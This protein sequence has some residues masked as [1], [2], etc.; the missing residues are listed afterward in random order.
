M[1]N[2]GA[3][4]TPEWTPLLMNQASEVEVD[5]MGRGKL[6]KAKKIQRHILAEYNRIVLALGHNP[7]PCID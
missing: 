2:N 6:A 4:L 5:A 7:P 1:A 3:Q